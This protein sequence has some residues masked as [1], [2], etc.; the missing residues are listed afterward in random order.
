MIVISHG[1][2]EAATLEFIYASNCSLKLNS[3][4]YNSEGTAPYHQEKKNERVVSPLLFLYL[5]T[6]LFS[7]YHPLSSP[8]SSLSL[9]RFI[10]ILP[11][12]PSVSYTYLLGSI[13]HF[14]SLLI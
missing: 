7:S 12:I 5:I 14:N 2:N 8:L 3:I 9:T 4:Y 1:L 13:Y 10:S 11:I 6:S